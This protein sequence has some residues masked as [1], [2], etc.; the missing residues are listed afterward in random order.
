MNISLA[1]QV[2]SPLLNSLQSSI[3]STPFNYKLSKNYPL[4]SK[5]NVTVSPVVTPSGSAYSKK[6]TWKLPRYGIITGACIKVTTVNSATKTATLTRKTRL[7]SR[8]FRNISLRSHNRTIQDNDDQYI[9]N[10]ISNSPSE[11]Q[12][13]YSDMTNPPEGIDI[14]GTVPESTFY[15][16]T[17]MFFGEQSESALDLAFCEPLEIVADVGTRSSIWGDDEQLFDM[18]FAS[19]E[20]VLF[21][22][23]LENETQAALTASQFP[24]SQNLTMLMNDSYREVGVEQAYTSD[25]TA[26]MTVDA[27]T[28][29]VVTASHFSVRDKD[30][31]S[32]L[33][34]ISVS[35]VSSGQTLVDS[36][37]RTNIYENAQF[38]KFVGTVPSASSGDVYSIY[39][40]FDNDKTYI[41][42]AEAFGSLNQPRF[43]VVVDTSSLGGATTLEMDVQHDYASLITV[44]SASGSVT[45]S[46]SN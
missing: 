21:Y 7:G 12:S 19:V 5:S 15:A 44:D 34:I 46:L 39:Y 25:D 18:D 28:N 38:G 29:H 36:T 41:S 1:S 32:L 37:R 43:T 20:L 4:L 40:G 31:N 23:N 35:M 6:I 2:E 22:V 42:G 3:V 14:F 33:P 10:R 26:T 30:D 45:R 17:F 9:D 11:K 13:A 27:K 8:F 16:P 24:L